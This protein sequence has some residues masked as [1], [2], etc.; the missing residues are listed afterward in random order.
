MYLTLLPQELSSP[1][2][3][4]MYKAL[5]TGYAPPQLS[6]RQR[7]LFVEGGSYSMPIAMWACVDFINLFSTSMTFIKRLHYK[8]CFLL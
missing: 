1:L 5:D 3:A 7:F 8:Q 4:L 2:Y 6:L